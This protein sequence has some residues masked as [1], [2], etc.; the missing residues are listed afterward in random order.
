LNFGSFEANRFEP[1]ENDTGPKIKKNIKLN[2]MVKKPSEKSNRKRT[3]Q[4]DKERVDS[5]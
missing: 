5:L 3:V 2:P 4:S 1:S